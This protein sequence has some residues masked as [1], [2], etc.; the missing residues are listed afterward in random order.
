MHADALVKD[1]RG[2]RWKIANA[3]F[4]DDANSANLAATRRRHRNPYVGRARPQARYLGVRTVFAWPSVDVLYILVPLATLAVATALL[5]FRW[6]L[7][8]GQFDDLETPPLR[9]VFDEA[10]RE[11]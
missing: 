11:K 3:R 7:R 5:A 10:D 9:A 2:Y 1:P 6:A 4:V 8:S